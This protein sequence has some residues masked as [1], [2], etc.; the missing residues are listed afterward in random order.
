MDPRIPSFCI[1]GLLVACGSRPTAIETTTPER[2][3]A[4]AD[5]TR[6]AAARSSAPVAEPSTATPPC[7]L[8]PVYFEYDSNLLDRRARDAL[9][10][11]ASCLRAHPE[12]R[13]TLVGGADERGTEEYNFA[14]G[15]RR[16]RSVYSYFTDS[17]IGS[18]RLRVHTV[19]EE[20]ASGETE[21][22]MAR[23]RRVEPR[24]SAP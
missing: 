5:A 16:A 4:A 24:T 9:A 3:A 17:G 10:S 20:W 15:D 2:P 11:D 1:A 21:E 7:S 19:G 18:E 14:L 12:L 22:A 13:V 8:D 6:A 23:D